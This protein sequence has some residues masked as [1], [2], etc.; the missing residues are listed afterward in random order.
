VGDQGLLKTEDETT[1]AH[2]EPVPEDNL[3]TILNRHHPVF[4]PT[5]DGVVE[6]EG[7]SGTIII[8]EAIYYAQHGQ[9]S[10]E[11]RHNEHQ[12]SRGKNREFNFMA[13]FDLEL[14][15]AAKSKERRQGT[16]VVRRI[17][18]LGLKVKATIAGEF[19]PRT[20]QNTADK[21]CN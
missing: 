19:G 18:A 12:D 15:L 3:N 7:T 6:L 21:E 16:K 17:P 4:P 1:G 9:H 5:V 10:A 8:D 20:V 14:L 11:T 2:Q 13:R